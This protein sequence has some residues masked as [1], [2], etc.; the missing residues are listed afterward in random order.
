MCE[1][2]LLVVHNPG[3]DQRGGGGGGEGGGGGPVAIYLVSYPRIN[4]EPLDLPQ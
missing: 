3:A 4:G 1:Q 2:Q